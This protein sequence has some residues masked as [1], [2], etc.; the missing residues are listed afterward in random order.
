MNLSRT[1]SLLTAAMM[2]VPQGVL[3]NPLNGQVVNGGAMIQGQGTSTVTIT[4]STNRAIIN[5]NTFN[6][7]VGDLTRFVQPNSGAVALNRVTGGLGPSQI[8]GT[9]TANGKVF[10]VN[11]DGILFGMGSKVDTAGFLATTNDIKYSDFMAGNYKFT[12][13]GRLDASIVNLGRITAANGGFAA[14]VAPGVRNAGTITANLGHVALA[15]GNG[16][17][18]DFYGDKLITLQVG[19]QIANRVIDV[20][21]GQPLDALVKNEGKLKANGG[22][23]E[24]TAAAARNVVDAVINTTGVIE[25]NSIGNRRGMIVLGAATG[26][27]KSSGLPTQTVKVSGTLTTSGRRKGERGGTVQITGEAIALAGARI[28]ASGYSGGGTVLVGGDTG[29]GNQTTNLSEFAPANP[30]PWPVVTATTVSVDAATVIN[31]SATTRGDGGKALILSNG[32]TSVAGLISASGG[33]FGGNGG[34]VETSGQSV[35]VNGIRVNTSASGGV[36]GLWLVDAPSLTVDGAAASTISSNLAT[37]N[38]TLLTRSGAEGELGVK[39][40]G[41]GDITINSPIAWSSANTLALDA[42]RGIAINAPITIS[43]PGGLRLSAAFDPVLTSVLLLS[44]GNGANVQFTGTP[45]SGQS[46]VINGQRYELLYSMA[47]VQNIN[48]ST[49]SLA[50]LYALAKPLDGGAVDGWTPIGVDGAGNVL[51]GGNGFAGTFQGLGNAI[52]NL[53]INSPSNPYVGLFGYVGSSGMIANTR[54]IGGTVTG[55]FDVGGLVGR[56]FGTVTGSYTTDSVTGSLNAGVGGLVGINFGTVNQSYATG[57]VSDASSSVT[58]VGGLVGNNVGTVTQSY[59]TGLVSGA[60]SVGGLVGYNSGS[61]SRSYATGNVNAAGAGASAGGLVGYNVKGVGNVGGTISQ[62]Y[63]SGAVMVSGIGAAGG[64]LVGRND[65][66][67]TVTQSYATGA[68]S[69]GASTDLGG[70][71]GQNIGTI[72]ESFASGAVS[73]GPGSVMGGLV[74]SNSATV[75]GG[76]D[77]GPVLVTGTVSTSY[78]DKQTTGQQHSAGSADSFGLTTA[79]AFKQASYVGWNFSSGGTWFMVDGLTRPFLQSEWSTTITN[80]HQ[81]QLMDMNLGATY[82]LANNIDLGA[83]LANRS[84]MWSAQGFAPIGETLTSFL[85]PVAQPFTGTFDG[86]GQV[87]DGLTITPTAVGSIFNGS[88]GMFGDNAGTI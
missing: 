68:V 72:T 86:R 8:Y 63:A 21:T 56:N 84:G 35:D 3:A 79:N 4:Q 58:A 87:I 10:L 26:G 49:K 1:L 38:V 54:L 15:S 74:G 52:S 18:L 78:W 67:S 20:A 28:N 6:L 23:V 80:A 27:N 62:S 16:F 33:R 55:S 44:F 66:F 65:V 57:T 34:F 73:G 39:G 77:H 76:I 12:I 51:N 30:L 14:L 32:L 53:T 17:T 48:A 64:G 37:T 70:L 69:G 43:G 45:N 25:A 82:T 83:A 11:P 85:G 22:Q 61:V 2:V 5:W 41:G 40:G 31:V 36:T 24:L 19:D 42:N 29:R 88:I 13:P 46:L 60:S 50:G 75:S 47:D 59:A 71:V 81:L 9:I 7:G